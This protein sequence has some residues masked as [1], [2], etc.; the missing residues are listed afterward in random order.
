MATQVAGTMKRGGARRR[1]KVYLVRSHPPTPSL[2][3]TDFR[4]GAAHILSARSL[5]RR[6]PAGI[7]PPSPICGLRWSPSD[8]R[9][10]RWRR[11]EFSITVAFLRSL[12][13]GCNRPPVVLS[14]CARGRRFYLP[15][16]NACMQFVS[17]QSN[18][19]ARITGWRN[20]KSDPICFGWN[21][22]YHALWGT[23]CSG[24]NL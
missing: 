20:E 17:I 24:S 16:R 2:D 21:H 11:Y 7:G 22:H 5:P 14:S 1:R 8:S 19:W 12:F 6:L 9:N 4:P 3:G 13:C 23:S 10:R 15:S 18:R